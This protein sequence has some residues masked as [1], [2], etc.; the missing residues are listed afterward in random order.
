MVYVLPVSEPVDVS[1][2]IT[3]DWRPASLW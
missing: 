2:E 1:A 3:C